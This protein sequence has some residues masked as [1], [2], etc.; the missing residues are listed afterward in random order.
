MT[1]L[2]LAAVLIRCGA[3]KA[4]KLSGEEDKE[5]IGAAMDI[6]DGFSSVSHQQI[7]GIGRGFL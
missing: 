5:D 2:K 6:I 4:N 1:A 3:A 7:P